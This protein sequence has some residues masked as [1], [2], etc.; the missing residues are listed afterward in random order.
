MIGILP[1]LI[2]GVG[3]AAPTFVAYGVEKRL[4]KEPERF[5]KGAIEAV[6]APEAANN[7]YAISA[8]IPLLTL[9]IPG[10]ATVAVITGAFLIHG[11]TPG[12]FL[13]RDHPE[14]VWPIIASLYVGNVILL[15]LN[16]PLV[17]LWILLLR[18][19]YSILMALIV[20]F[21]S[22]GRTR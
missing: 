4:A 10:S 22:S 1:G 5:G 8:L 6:A 14:I 11:I 13:F 3:A 9:G 16:L 17:R 21:M 7:A 12:P 19:P 20:G 2:P 18:V 15:I